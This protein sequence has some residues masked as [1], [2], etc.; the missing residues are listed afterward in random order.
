[1][2]CSWQSI[3]GYR[4]LQM[5]TM[6]ITMYIECTR[7]IVLSSTVK[8]LYFVGNISRFDWS[9]ETTTLNINDYGCYILYPQWITKMES[10]NVRVNE[11][12]SQWMYESM[13]VRVHECTSQWMYESMNVRV[14]ECASPWM[15]ESMNVRVNECTSQWMYESMNVRVNEC[16]SQWTCLFYENHEISILPRK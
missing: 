7:Y 14:N 16:T 5:Q 11:C 8:S 15:Y 4:V 13:N 12:T 10:M 3:Y 1:M 2:S 6:C 9:A